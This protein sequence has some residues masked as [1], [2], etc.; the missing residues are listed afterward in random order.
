MSKKHL[1]FLGWGAWVAQSVKCQTSA[2]A[3]ISQLTSS[4]PTSGSVL[5]AQSLEPS[6]DSVSPSLS[7]P[8][9]FMLSLNNKFKKH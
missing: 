5:T 2:Q 7:A 1:K 4:S 9:L 6:S 3:M 8:P